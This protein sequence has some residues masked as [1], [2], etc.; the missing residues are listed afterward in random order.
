MIQNIITHKDLMILLLN[1]LGDNKWKFGFELAQEIEKLNFNKNEF[2]SLDV[3][4]AL[5]YMENKRIVQSK[6]EWINN[7][8]RIFYKLID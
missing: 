1:I 2:N 6:K 3:Y 7:R 8:M 4:P 5:I